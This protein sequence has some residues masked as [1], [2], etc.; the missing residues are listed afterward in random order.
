MR[1]ETIIIDYN[2]IISSNAQREHLMLFTYDSDYLSPRNYI[3]KT[4]DR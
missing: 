3:F 2:D 4:V 1:E